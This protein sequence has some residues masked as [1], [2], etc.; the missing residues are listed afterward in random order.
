MRDSWS[1]P[2]PREEPS[3]SL[4]SWWSHHPQLPSAPCPMFPHLCFRP[5]AGSLSGRMATLR[6]TPDAPGALLPR[7]E[8]GAECHPD[9]EE[10]D[11]EEEQKA[12][13]VEAEEEEEEDGDGMEEQSAAMGTHACLGHGGRARVPILQGAG[14][15]KQ[16]EPWERKLG[17]RLGCVR[18]GRALGT[19]RLLMGTRIQRCRGRSEPW[20]CSLA[21][22]VG[23]PRSMC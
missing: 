22:K 12:D 2:P 16:P 17:N 18:P 10:D 21:D 1:G 15:R 14:K 9:Q 13:E 19:S 20:L 4:P 6:A 23:A 7:A 8:D 5:S 3:P 11:K